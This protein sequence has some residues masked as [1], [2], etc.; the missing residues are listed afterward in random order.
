M[1]RNIVLFLHQAIW[2][3]QDTPVFSLSR[4]TQ[5]GHAVSRPNVDRP[6]IVTSDWSSHARA[7]RDAVDLEAF[8]SASVIG[9]DRSVV[10]HN[11]SHHDVSNSSRQR[12]RV[13]QFVPRSS[14]VPPRV[15]RGSF[16]ES[17]ELAFEAI[18]YKFA[19]D[20]PEVR[21]Q[22]MKEY[23]RKVDPFN[24]SWS[25]ARCGPS[26]QVG[27]VQGRVGTSFHVSAPTQQTCDQPLGVRVDESRPQ[28]E[29][30]PPS[31]QDPESVDRFCS[32]G[33]QANLSSRVSGI[34]SLP[35]DVP[36][37]MDVSQPSARSTP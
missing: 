21:I 13:R 36:A 34:A 28:K 35:L 30:I 33:R 4:D 18:A 10:S 23:A 7:S 25:S 11:V 12:S 1:K 3:L 37:T 24:T 32:P 26:S 31:S 9:D 8:V 22:K 14:S 16:T 5:Y 15:E 17:M 6:D 2:T 27:Q 29:G 20:P 19:H